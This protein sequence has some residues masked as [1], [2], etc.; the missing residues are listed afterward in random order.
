MYVDVGQC[1]GSVKRKLQLGIACLRGYR[2]LA[3]IRNWSAGV[4]FF[5]F[6]GVEVRV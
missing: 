4:R 6:C 2:P 3:W 5:G 1:G